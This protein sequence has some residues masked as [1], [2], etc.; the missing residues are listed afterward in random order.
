MNRIAKYLER[1]EDASAIIQLKGDEWM[2]VLIQEPDF[3]AELGSLLRPPWTRQ[4]D[5]GEARS[6]GGTSSSS[7]KGQGGGRSS[8]WKPRLASKKWRAAPPADGSDEPPPCTQACWQ[9]RSHTAA[10]VAPFPHRV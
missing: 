4:A 3:S 8:T 6:G 2:E 5:D 10:F 1:S 7:G 9:C